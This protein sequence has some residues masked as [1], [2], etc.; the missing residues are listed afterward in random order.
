M[1]VVK[2]DTCYFV[3]EHSIVR[4]IWGRSDAV[5]V[6]FAGAAAEFALN[7][8]VD[9]LYF[10]G[11]LPSDPIG[12]FFS[13]VSYAHKIVFAER[14]PAHNAIDTIVGIHSGVEEKRG[15]RI[16]DAA[17]RDVLFMLIDYTIRSYE[18]LERQLSYSEKQEVFSVFYRM[19][20]RMEIGGLPES[21]EQ[22][23][24]QREEHLQQNLQFSAHT[25]DLFKRYR[26]H[27][28]GIRYG[29]LMELQK[30]VTPARVRQLLGYRRFSFLQ[31]LLPFYKLGRMVRA[32]RFIR[33]ILL[34]SKYRDELKALDACS[35]S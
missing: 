11:R 21:F 18:L 20:H 2:A 1:K 14:Q 30:M 12:R 33:N 26:S 16:P 28:G 10:T 19:G 4:Q 31:L 7:K 3:N 29:L 8:A 5:L 13:T 9:W 22:W 23:E 15:A 6:I 27:L 35:F 17:Y 34:P 25:G 32:D 24:K